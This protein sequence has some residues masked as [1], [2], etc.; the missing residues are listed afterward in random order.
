LNVDGTIEIKVVDTGRGIAP[1]FL[2]HVFDRFRQADTSTT[3]AY[4]GLGL[5]LSIVRYLVELHGGTVGAESAGEGQGATFRVR[6]PLAGGSAADEQPVPT[7]FGAQLPFGRASVIHGLQVLLVDDDE[8]ARNMLG[9][10]LQEHGAVVRSATSGASA[11]EA[12]MRGKPDVL[13]CD[14]GLPG[15]NG[16][17]LIRMIRRLPI[18][19]GGGVPALAL[20]AY[21]SVA[22]REEALAA[23]F[24]EHLPK[25][26]DPG[27]F[28]AA[29]VQLAHPPS[30]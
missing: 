6:L 9:L 29:V 19:T 12:L 11:M 5:G 15:T 23:G 24:Q 16:Y 2:P 30:G 18:E 20:T 17:D 3:R 22:D 27:A 26:V 13:V 8:D 21:A 4:G 10:V 28:M 7:R 1:D 14:I 25:P